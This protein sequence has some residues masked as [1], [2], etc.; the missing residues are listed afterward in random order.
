MVAA[1][2]ALAPYLDD[3]SVTSIELSYFDTAPVI[4][5]ENP[6]LVVPDIWEMWSYYRDASGK[7]VMEHW[8]E[9]LNRI[10]FEGKE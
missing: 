1:K 2:A 9:R 7:W 4:L 5:G 8:A 6:D 3:P 10:A